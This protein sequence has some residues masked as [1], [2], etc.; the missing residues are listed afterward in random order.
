MT[1]NETGRPLELYFG[2]EKGHHTQLILLRSLFLTLSDI[3]C[4]LESIDDPLFHLLEFYIHND[5]P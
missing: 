5:A 1:C 2:I 3:N 4:T